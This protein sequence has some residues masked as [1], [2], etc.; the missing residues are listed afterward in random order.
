MSPLGLWTFNSSSFFSYSSSSSSDSLLFRYEA[1]DP[2]VILPR[3]EL[4]GSF[5]ESGEL[6][7]KCISYVSFEVT[8]RSAILCTWLRTSSSLISSKS[9]SWFRWNVTR[10]C[11]EMVTVGGESVVLVWSKGKKWCGLLELL[12][13][14]KLTKFSYPPNNFDWHHD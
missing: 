8:A 13:S 4:G 1:S 10:S 7:N 14:G 5:S 11:L 2:S 12:I 9:S 6:D 3:D